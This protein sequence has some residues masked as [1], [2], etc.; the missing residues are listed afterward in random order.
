VCG[1]DK[2]KLVAA[3]D[4][5]YD[6]YLEKYSTEPSPEFIQQQL[7]IQRTMQTQ[8]DTPTPAPTP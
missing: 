8:T 4:W 7:D 1:T 5:R 2:L 6:R 3:R